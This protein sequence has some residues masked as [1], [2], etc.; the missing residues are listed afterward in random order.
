[1]IVPATMR[2]T[3]GLVLPIRIARGSPFDDFR[4]FY[5]HLHT[6]RKVGWSTSLWHMADASQAWPSV[7][8]TVLPRSG[9][10]VWALGAALRLFPPSQLPPRP[11]CRRLRPLRPRQQRPWRPRSIDALS[12]SPAPPRTVLLAARSMVVTIGEACLILGQQDALLAV[13]TRL[14]R[15][16][17]SGPKRH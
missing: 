1:M 17:K 10:P 16:V 5:A 6:A 3:G 13:E 8:L 2:I 9:P 14:W 7:H 12:S 11:T 15:C 4:Y